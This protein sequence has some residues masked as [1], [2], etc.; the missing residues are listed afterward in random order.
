MQHRD[1]TRRNRL[2]MSKKL[3]ACITREA[4]RV[5]ADA[6]KAVCTPGEAMHGLRAAVVPHIHLLPGCGK[7]VP[8]P[9]VIDAPAV[10][11]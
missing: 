8:L 10:G 6:G 2:L 4:H 7:S 3:W 1:L 9:V 11:Q 5:E